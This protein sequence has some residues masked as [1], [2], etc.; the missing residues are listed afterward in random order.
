MIFTVTIGTIDEIQKL[1]IRTVPLGESPRRIAYQ[2]AT[3]TFGVITMRVDIQESNGVNIVRPSASTQAASVSSNTH[4]AAHNKPTN[5]VIDV[6]Q[7]VEVHNLLI[8]DQHTFEIL[9]AYTFMPTE[10]A[11][12]L[13]STKLGEDPRPYFIV[14]T[15]LFNP[16]D[17]EPKMGRILLFRWK[18]GKLSQV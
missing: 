18:D 15:A 5:T 2:E 10:Y 4:I 12:S 11:M 1:H 9:H 13:I 8:V 16:D 7:E 6:G 17:T 14:G 3:Q